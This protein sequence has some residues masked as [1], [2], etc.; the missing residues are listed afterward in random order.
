VGECVLGEIEGCGVDLGGQ[1]LGQV[2]DERLDHGGLNR[3]HGGQVQV[4][5]G[6]SAKTGLTPASDDS[7]HRKIGANM[8]ERRMHQDDSSRCRI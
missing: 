6:G 7:V 8:P 3:R 5:L 1:E 4:D 2:L